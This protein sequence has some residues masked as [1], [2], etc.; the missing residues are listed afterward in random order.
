MISTAA[1]HSY[2]ACDLDDT[3]TLAEWRAARHQERRALTR[4]RRFR[5]SS[6]RLRLA[7]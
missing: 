4:R 5:L 6:L 2:V 3:Q 7:H 1:P